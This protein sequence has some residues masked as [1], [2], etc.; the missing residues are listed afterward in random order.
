MVNLLELGWVIDAGIV[1]DY[2]RFAITNELGASV[3][4]GSVREVGGDAFSNTH[5]Q[6]I[7]IIRCCRSKNCGTVGHEDLSNCATDATT[8]AGNE[9]G[10]VF[11]SK[12]YVPPMTLRDLVLSISFSTE[13]RRSKSG[14]LVSLFGKRRLTIRF[15]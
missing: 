3:N 8:C 13:S 6:Q 5:L 11:K 4:V 14:V 9:Y 7:V 1:D 15:R 2:A 10:L 12:H